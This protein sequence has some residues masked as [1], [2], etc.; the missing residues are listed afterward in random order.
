[1]Y[2]NTVVGMIMGAVLIPYVSLGAAKAK[3]CQLKGYA[4]LELSEPVG[5]PE[6]SGILLAI[7]SGRTV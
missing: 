2:K 7:G 1:M 4:S 5:R 3:N 6:Y